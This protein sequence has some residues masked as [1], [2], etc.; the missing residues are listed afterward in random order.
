MTE[1]ELEKA[2]DPD[3][4]ASLQA[5]KRAARA[6]RKIAKQTDTCIVIVRDNKVIHITA[7]ELQQE[8]PE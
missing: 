8:N 1:Q 4:R 3:L 7:Q 6:A 5:I 2:K